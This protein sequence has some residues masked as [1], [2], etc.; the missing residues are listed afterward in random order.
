MRWGRPGGY[1]NLGENAAY[2]VVRE[3][4]EET[5]FL[6]NE[7]AATGAQSP[8][9]GAKTKRA[10]GVSLRRQWRP[11]FGRTVPLLQRLKSPECII[12]NS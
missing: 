4:F 3:V 5:R 10:R 11:H 7:F 2:T 9:A 1:S 8:P 6:A 12:L